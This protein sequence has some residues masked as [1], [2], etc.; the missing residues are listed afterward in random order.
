MNDP[1]ATHRPYVLSPRECIIKGVNIKLTAERTKN[2]IPLKN[3]PLTNAFAFEL[4]CISCY[5]K[6]F[7]ISDKNIFT[8]NSFLENRPD[9]PVAIPGVTQSLCSSIRDVFCSLPPPI[10]PQAAV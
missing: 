9:K 4:I 8:S 5:F 1:T 10:K 2:S 3:E 6:Y 7:F